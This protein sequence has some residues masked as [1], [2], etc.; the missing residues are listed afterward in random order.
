MLPVDQVTVQGVNQ[1]LEGCP[2]TIH[3]YVTYTGIAFPWPQLQLVFGNTSHA[4]YNHACN[5]IQNDQK[6]IPHPTV[7][8]SPLNID[9]KPPL[10]LYGNSWD[11]SL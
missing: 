8:I 6:K 2:P 7:L 4:L 1:N 3:A 9:P 10:Q 5:N 11:M